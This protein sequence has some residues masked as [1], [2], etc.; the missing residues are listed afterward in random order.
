MN[1]KISVVIPVYN[2]KENIRAVALELG[3]AFKSSSLTWESIWVDDGSGDGSDIELKAVLKELP[4]ARLIRFARNFGQTAAL[5]AGIQAASGE[6]IVTM[7]ADLQND[8]SDI[9]ALLKTASEGFDVV[10]G[11][12]K[13]RKDALLSRVLPSKIANFI[14][15]K[16]T[17]VDL[18]DYGCTLKI[19]K[20]SH[21]KTVELYGEMHRFLPALLGYMGATIAELPVNHRLRLKGRSKYGLIRIFKVTLDLFTVKFMG[22]F[23][24]K[25]IY[26]FGGLSLGLFSASTLMATFTLYKKVFEHV[27]V[28]DQPLFLVAIFFALAG[29]QF[30]FMG[31]MSE[32]LVRTYYRSTR[33]PA[34]VIKE[35]LVFNPK[36]SVN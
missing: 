8:P 11:W 18:H 10:S 2:E 32:I 17:G 34:Y 27:F 9:A 1:T 26:L 31:L 3:V 23:L 33:K 28:K 6:Y 35:T 7:D 19:Y 13:N 22:D 12:R 29:I 30:A 15:S 21:L 20:A 36:S 14:I 16:I 25:P 5:S 24:S 4:S